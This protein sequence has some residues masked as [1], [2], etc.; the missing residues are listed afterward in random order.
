LSSG[1]IHTAAGIGAAISLPIGYIASSYLN[2]AEMGMIV[3]GLIIGSKFVSPDHDVDGGNINYYYARK[4]IGTDFFLRTHWKPYSMGIK[5]R[6]SISHFPIL[7]TLYRIIYLLFPIT[8][9]L[10]ANQPGS[11][12]NLFLFS[13]VAQVIAIPFIALLV[14]LLQYSLIFYGILFLLGM[15]LSDILHIAFD[16]LHLV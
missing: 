5:H 14:I 15:I 16:L 1:R 12:L 2:P 4:Y 11:R 3:T 13:L 8:I 9:N 7:S 10:I 6:S